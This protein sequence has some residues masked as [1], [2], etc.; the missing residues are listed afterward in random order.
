MKTK[1]NT[2]NIIF[3][4]SVLATISFNSCEKLLDTELNDRIPNDEAISSTRDIQLVLNGA[5]DGLQSGCLLGGNLVIYSDLLA[6][7]A[8]VTNQQK[9]NK[10]GKY[11]IYHMITSPQIGE[12]A[13]MWSTAYASINRSNYVIDA[14]DSGT[15]YDAQF[16][17]NKDRMKGEALFIRAVCHFELVRF[18]ALPYDVNQ[19]GSNSQLGIPYRK[20]ATKDFKNLDMARVTVEEVYVNII[21]DLIDAKNL[22]TSAGIIS[23]SQSASAMA[24]TAYLAK[25]YFQ[26]GDYENAA[27]YANEVIS[28]QVY[29]LDEDLASM[30]KLSGDQ[31]SPEII[32]QLINI[33]TDNSN[34]LIDNY[35]RSENPLF[36]T[37]SDIYNLFEDTDIRRELINK[38][39]VIYYIK[40]YDKTLIS[41]VS[42]PINRTIIRLAEMHLIR[43][44]SNL[45][46][47]NGVT[48]DAYSSY[49]AL[50]QRAFGDNYTPETILLE[51][52]LD[53]VREERRREL[54]F[55][56][57]RYHNLKRL[58]MPLRDGVVWN[59]NAPVFKIPADEISG[60]SLM[61]QNP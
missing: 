46:A 52:L 22:M 12:I 45:L 38:Y 59:S 27:L 15:I 29:T 17:A 37:T 31:S 58:Q 18:F 54:C 16:D 7:D 49:N 36:Q 41:G 3:L 50:R 40:K 44:E 6:D 4:I 20:E 21:Q 35:S 19:Q 51:E 23:S 24:A 13:C 8:I 30:Y 39:F 47:I 60:N 25:V 2:R 26:M 42:Q 43:A 32:F 56:G 10:F 9:L 1:Y 28:S 57:D 53:K 48:A 5:Y 61:I 33:E 14:V 34:S 11:E 55:E